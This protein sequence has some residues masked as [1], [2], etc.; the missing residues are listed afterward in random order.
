MNKCYYVADTFNKTR[1]PGYH[2]KLENAQAKA[3]KHDNLTRQGR[4][5][6]CPALVNHMKVSKE[7]QDKMG[8]WPEENFQKS[9]R[10]YFEYE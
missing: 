5:M 10:G 6:I 9:A 4:F 3:L 8:I 2:T 1:L 7:E